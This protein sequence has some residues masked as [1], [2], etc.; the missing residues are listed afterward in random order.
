MPYALSRQTF[1]S[2]QR[3]LEHTSAFVTK[4]LS[5]LAKS[6]TSRSAT[7]D[8][9][10]QDLDAIIGKMQGLKRKL[11]SLH[12]EESKLNHSA[13]AR[14]Q[15]LEELYSMESLADVKYENWSRV[16]LSR[17]LVDYL[18]RSGYVESASHL[19]SAKGIEELVDVDAFVAAHKIEKSLREGRSVTP[20]LNWCKENSQGLK[21]LGGN[22]EF[23]LR[24]QQYIELVRKG[25]EGL[26]GVGGDNDEE[27]DDRMEGVADEEEDMAGGVEL[28]DVERERKVAG[29]EKLMEARIHAKK[30]LAPG[31]A[32]TEILGKAAGLLA[33]KPWDPVEPYAVSILLPSRFLWVVLPAIQGQSEGIP[34]MY[35]ELWLTLR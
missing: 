5:S 24:L 16:R 8:K 1:K 20:S 29:A 11:E 28:E 30:W 31:S 19:A 32:D 35:L 21:R 7:P 18:L 4:D 9:T 14:I 33:F 2:A 17:L 25:H 23:E 10:L 3:S 6:S 15:H 12:E 27:G 26:H 22:L 34:S 13:T